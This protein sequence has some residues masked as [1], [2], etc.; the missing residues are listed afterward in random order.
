VVTTTDS[1]WLTSS[2]ALTEIVA[3]PGSSSSEKANDTLPPRKATTCCD[4]TRMG[5][6]LRVSSDRRPP[7]RAAA[8]VTEDA[9]TAQEFLDG[10]RGTAALWNASTRFVD[11][12]ALHGTPETGIN[13][14]RFPGPRGPVIYRDLCLR[15]YRIVGDGSQHR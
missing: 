1:T 12:F 5:N 9:A 3:S 4:G 6:V 8:I 10:Y 7:A 2:R 14:D 11:G 13:V 15:Q